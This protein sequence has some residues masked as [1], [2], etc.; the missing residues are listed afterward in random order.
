MSNILKAIRN[1]AG[2][3]V[4]FFSLIAMF[5]AFVSY[6]S[7]LIEVALRCSLMRKL[8][9]KSG[10]IVEFLVTILERKIAQNFHVIVSI[11]LYVPNNKSMR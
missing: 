3:F 6:K 2:I 1:A 10:R 9:M 8:L 5:Q 7:S 11:T 4:V